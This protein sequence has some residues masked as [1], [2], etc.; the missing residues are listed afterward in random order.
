MLTVIEKLIHLHSEQRGGN[1]EGERKVERKIGEK[2][3]KGDDNNCDNNDLHSINV[4]IHNSS[5]VNAHSCRSCFHQNYI[6]LLEIAWWPT[7]VEYTSAWS[8]L[9]HPDALYHHR[10][11]LGKVTFLKT[12]L[13]LSC[14]G[15]WL[16]GCGCLLGTIHSVCKEPCKPCHYRLQGQL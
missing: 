7:T 2:M 5:N 1:L 9:C 8:P 10:V 14:V 12:A 6:Q 15:G 4:A 13:M 3:E 11:G 16:L